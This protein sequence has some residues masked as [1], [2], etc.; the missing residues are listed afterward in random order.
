LGVVEDFLA[1]M[2][3]S[4][5]RRAEAAKAQL[6]E[7]ELVASLIDLAPPPALQLSS[8][9]FDVIAEMKL[10]SPALGQLRS[11]MDDSADQRIRA[12]VQGGAAAISVLTEPDRFD[13]S[14]DHLRAASA[15]RV[16]Q[17][18]ADGRARRIPTMRKDFL[19]DPYQVLEARAAG[20]GGVLLI[21]RMLDDPT[22]QRLCETA[23]KQRLFVLIETFD[24]AD[25]ERANRLIE[26]LRSN[27]TALL[28]GVNSRDLVSLQVVPD[29]LEKLVSQLPDSV[30]RVAESGVITPSDAARMASAGYDLA[31]IGGALMQATDP[32]AQLA[33]MLRA[34]RDAAV[35]Q[36]ASL[37]E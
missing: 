34:A 1:A 4:S 21:V 28:I 6:A 36:R 8:Q 22:L 17:Q 30:P 12:Y 9:G 29:R 13:G 19:V 18:S 24:F 20:A 37:R 14:L 5:R 31:L 33:A 16:V 25:I 35:Q 27:D 10:R 2:A 15:L 23:L 26:Q 7:T 32:E 3:A 11:K